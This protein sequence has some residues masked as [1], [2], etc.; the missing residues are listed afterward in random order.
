[1]LLGE[2]EVR[3]FYERWSPSVPCFCRLSLGDE[4]HGEEAA[5]EVF[6]SYIRAGLPT[7]TAGMPIGLFQCAVSVTGDACSLGGASQ[8][9][10]HP[11]LRAMLL[12]PYEFG[13]AFI[14]RYVLR[15][16]VGTVA[17]SAGKSERWVRKASLQAML[18]IRDLLPREFFKEPIR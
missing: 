10:A 1:M 15:L 16:D 3:S 12:L 5:R 9:E 8:R 18:Q 2:E 7:E 13:A 6:L 17:S 4:A 14:L 11:L